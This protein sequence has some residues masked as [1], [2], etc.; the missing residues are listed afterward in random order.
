M[1]DPPWK[2]Y[3][4]KEKNLSTEEKSKRKKRKVYFSDIA[5]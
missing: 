1:K 2:T 5:R 3:V 4:W